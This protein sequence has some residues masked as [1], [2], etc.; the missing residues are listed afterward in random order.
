MFNYVGNSGRTRRAA[1][2]GIAL[3]AELAAA[4]ALAACGVAASDSTS[5]KKVAAP[6]EIENW[7]TSVPEHP[8]SIGRTA[9]LDAF[10]KHNPDLIRLTH[11]QSGA[12]QS[13]DKFKAAIAGGIP[14]NIAVFYQ[15]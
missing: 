7:N 2:R 3:V 14:P 5:A 12:G 6:V 10:A 13:V 8:E 11:G 15:Y 4:S 1:A 9:V